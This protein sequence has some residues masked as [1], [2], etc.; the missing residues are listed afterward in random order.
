[1]LQRL[2]KLPFRSTPLHRPATRGSEEASSPS[3]DRVT[4]WSK[5]EQAEP[6]T[7]VRDILNATE[8]RSLKDLL[9]RID[10]AGYIFHG[11]ISAEKSSPK[12]V[13]EMQELFLDNPVEMRSKI[14]VA[15]AGEP[16]AKVEG[17]LDLKLLDELTHPTQK[18]TLGLLALV[19]RYGAFEYFDDKEKEWS[20]A[21][22]FTAL[23]RLEQRQK[24]RLE[25]GDD[26]IRIES[27]EG[28][29]AADFFQGRGN[30]ETLEEPALARLINQR[31]EQGYQL[32]TSDYN[33][34]YAYLKARRNEGDIPLAYRDVS[35]G[36]LQQPDLERRQFFQRHFEAVGADEEVMDFALQADDRWPADVRAETVATLY[37]Y[38][39]KAPTD[40]WRRNTLGDVQMAYEA[41]EEH[42]P[43]DPRPSAQKMGLLLSHLGLDA[44]R[45]VERYVLDELPLL[46]SP[47]RI[48]AAYQRTLAAASQGL[49]LDR[50]R[51]M[52]YIGELDPSP[53]ALLTIEKLAQT[54]VRHE[55]YKGERRDYAALLSQKLPDDQREIFFQTLE[56]CALM[57]RPELA[58]TVYRDLCDNPPLG[59]LLERVPERVGRHMDLP[60]LS[61]KEFT[62][63]SQAYARVREKWRYTDP[64][65]PL[66]QLFAPWKGT[67]L[68]ERLELIEGLA[69]L[70]GE[71]SSHTRDSDVLLQMV[72]GVGSR[73][74]SGVSLESAVM[75]AE[76]ALSLEDLP[77]FAQHQSI[78]FEQ[79]EDAIQV[80]DVV[81]DINS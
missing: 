81:I 2:E 41:L 75:E 65:P 40:S 39:R 23:Q 58:Q 66:K 49:P 77:A 42:H 74:Q 32:G 8:E 45:E 18:G 61:W 54:A 53:Q 24:I 29:G 5:L 36:S 17:T 44:R 57:E 72:Q 37:S 10:G 73:V 22:R 52:C 19:D 64:V 79:F 27:L 56:A 47:E 34:Q 33:K 21:G 59:E 4:L 46:A 51:E 15:G 38:L 25:T 20:K 63:F 6:E 67:T 80:G 3:P 62:Q 48:E 12:S 76:Q 16:L 55:D 71:F 31:V 68:E 50:S 78:D 7:S 30:E 14:W 28:A 11:G 43:E 70:G 35:V 26:Q 9:G 60:D 69:A 13:E 1:M